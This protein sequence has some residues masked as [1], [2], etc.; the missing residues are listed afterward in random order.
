MESGRYVRE[1]IKAVVGKKTLQSLGNDVREL[2]LVDTDN[3]F[4]GGCH[5]RG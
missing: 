2:R 5:E 4:V 3:Y 1:A